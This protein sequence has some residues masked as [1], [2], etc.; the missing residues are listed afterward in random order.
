[1]RLW[2]VGG[3]G[4]TNLFAVGANG[5]ILRYNGTSWSPMSSTVSA[6]LAGVYAPDANNAFVVGGNGTILRF[7]GTSWSTM[8]SP[9][10]VLLYGVWGTGVNDVYAV[11]ENG[12]ILRYNGTAWSAMTVSTTQTFRGISG[13]GSTAAAVGYASTIAIGSG[14]TAAANPVDFSIPRRI[15][16]SASQP[17][18][19]GQSP[20]GIGAES[21]KTPGRSRTPR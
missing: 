8:Q 19:P 10:N 20:I 1:V 3:S 4:P 17:G 6:F 18:V 5:T 21:V 13:S 14:T 2:G 12:V 15:P 7:N 16:V 9:T 11:G